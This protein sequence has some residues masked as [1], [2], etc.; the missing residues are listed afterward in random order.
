MRLRSLGVVLFAALALAGCDWAQ[1]GWSPQRTNFSPDPT[2]STSNV[3]GLHLVWQTAAANEDANG[4]STVAAGVAYVPRSSHIDAYDANG[5]RSCGGTPRTCTPL[6]TY[7]SP[8]G[9]PAFQTPAV[10]ATRC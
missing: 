5:N 2:I 8:G 1:L 10:A 6:R 3:A 7:M 9:P 4:P